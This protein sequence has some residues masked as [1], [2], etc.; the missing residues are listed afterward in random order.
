M[1][2][3]ISASSAVILN[4]AIYNIGGDESSHSVM[5]CRLVSSDPPK[6]KSLDLQGYSFKGYAYREA[7]V[8]GSKIVYFGSNNK[9][10]TF[11]LEKEE[12]EKLRVVREDGLIGPILQ[13]SIMRVQ[14][15]DLRV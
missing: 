11:V 8:V 5:C 6:W 13:C 10:A 7:L 9:N 3:A 15:E 1:P 4:S 2:E 14:K 12:E